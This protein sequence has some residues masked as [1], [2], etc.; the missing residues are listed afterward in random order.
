MTL[1]EYGI[2]KIKKDKINL[3]RVEISKDDKKQSKYKL[4]ITRKQ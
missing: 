2:Y 3:K 4:G 1:E